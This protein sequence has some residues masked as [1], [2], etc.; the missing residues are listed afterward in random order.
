MRYELHSDVMICYDPEDPMFFYF[1]DRENDFFKQ[2]KLSII[3]GGVIA[4]ILLI[5]A[6][7]R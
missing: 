5:I 2:Y 4:V 6:Q 7:T 3:I 1:P